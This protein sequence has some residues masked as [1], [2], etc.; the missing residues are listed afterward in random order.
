MFNNKQ[1]KRFKIHCWTWIS[2]LTPKIFICFSVVPPGIEPGTQGF[3][4]LCSTNWAMAPLFLLSG[5]KGMDFFCSSQTFWHFFNRNFKNGPSWAC[6]FCLWEKKQLIYFAL[7]PFL[8]TFALHFERKRVFSPYLT[9]CIRIVAQLV[10]YYVR[11]VGVGSSSL[12]FPTS[13]SDERRV[14]NLI[15]HRLFDVTIILHS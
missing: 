8:R 5:C 15:K 14:K 13:W 9:H 6:A 12:L 7:C 2:C 3:S 11:D 4:V 1:K 10:A